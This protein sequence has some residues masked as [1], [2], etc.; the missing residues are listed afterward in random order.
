VNID[1]AELGDWLEGDG[2]LR[3]QPG[4]RCSLACAC[5]CV[6]VC[7]PVCVPVCVFSA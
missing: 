2:V 7:V 3:L 5:V 1:A 4:R 6:C